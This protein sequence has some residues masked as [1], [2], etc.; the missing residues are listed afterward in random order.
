MQIFAIYLNN[1]SLQGSEIKDQFTVR[2]MSM[3]YKLVDRNKKRNILYRVP[4]ADK[5]RVKTIPP[6]FPF[7]RQGNHAFRQDGRWNNASFQDRHIQG[8][9]DGHKTALLLFVDGVYLKKNQWSMLDRQCNGGT[10]NH[11]LRSSQSVPT[12]KSDFCG[13]LLCIGVVVQNRTDLIK[14]LDPRFER[15][16][17]FS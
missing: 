6:G 7:I 11:I 8:F 10:R 5:F 4:D 17:R 1:C 15:L 2:Y 13:L 3:G 14:M 9:D 12:Q 16:G